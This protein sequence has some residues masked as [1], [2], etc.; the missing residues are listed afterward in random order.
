MVRMVRL[1]LTRTR[2]WL[3][4]P[5]WLPLHHIRMYTTYVGLGSR[6]RTCDPLL[7]KQMRYQ[8]ALH[9]EKNLVPDVW[10]EQTTYRLQGDCTTT[11]LIR[12]TKY[13]SSLVV[14]SGNDPL[15]MPYEGSTHPS[16]SYHHIETLCG[17]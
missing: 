14:I 11:V 6:I 9:T 8:T 10:F 4:R 5:A 13:I 16:T 2:H 7:P 3:L 12:H 15:F 1:E 17:A